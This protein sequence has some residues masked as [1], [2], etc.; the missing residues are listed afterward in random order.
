MKIVGNRPTSIECRNT[1]VYVMADLQRWAKSYQV[2][3]APT[4][5]WQ[6]I[7][8]PQLGRGALAAA[9]EGRAPTT[10]MPSFAPSGARRST[11]ASVPN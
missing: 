4:P 9:D 8:F 11:S 6:S 7:D 10:S 3:F 2:T 5:Y 1:A